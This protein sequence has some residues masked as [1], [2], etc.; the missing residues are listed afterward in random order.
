MLMSW[1]KYASE[2]P[3]FEEICRYLDTIMEDMKRESYCE[4][5]SDEGETLS[6]EGS[7]RFP[8]RSPS[9]KSGTNFSSCVAVFETI[10]CRFSE[11]GSFWKQEIAQQSS[12][13]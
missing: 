13:A 5:D 2:R 3:R 1:R 12:T 6:R 8:T 4:S 11:F 9:I 7:K 10:F